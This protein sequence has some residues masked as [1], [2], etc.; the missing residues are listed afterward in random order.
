MFDR[1]GFAGD[2]KAMV[3]DPGDTVGDPVDMAA[4][5]A[6]AQ[7]AG[8]AIPVAA[9]FL[10][11]YAATLVVAADPDLDGAN[12]HSWGPVCASLGP[13]IRDAGGYA[14]TGLDEDSSDLVTVRM[15]ANHANQSGVPDA[16]STIGPDGR[17]AEPVTGDNL[18][19]TDLDI[20]DS[21]GAGAEP[22]LDSDSEE[23]DLPLDNKVQAFPCAVRALLVAVIRVVAVALPLEPPC[24]LGEWL[25][26]DVLECLKSQWVSVNPP[27]VA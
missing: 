15:C 11:V 20:H 18:C 24:S 22:E 17:C 12:L 7:V 10:A 13:G 14:T 1:L 25:C 5:G 8:V 26:R 16:A 23:L 9:E 27:P 4:A 21:P 19:S 2:R 3:A 6:G